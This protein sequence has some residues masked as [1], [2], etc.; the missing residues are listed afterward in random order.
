MLPRQAIVVVVD[1]WQ[2]AFFGAYGNSW[3]ET[4]HLDQ[5]A[6]GGCVFD[7]ALAAGDDLESAYTGYWNARHPLEPT[8]PF[9][10][11][12]A[13]EAARVA[14]AL[15]TDEPQVAGHGAAG[16]FDEL[17]RLPPSTA[18]SSA[19]AVEETHLA[20]VL[21]AAAAVHEELP[22]ASLLWI[23]ARGFSGP[24]DAP[25][26]YRERLADPDD[27][28]PP[29]LVTPPVCRLAADA[30][31]D[32]L[33]GYRRAYGGQVAAADAL[34]GAFAAAISER[35][36]SAETMLLFCSP[37]GYPLGEHGVVGHDPHALY[38]ET[39]HVPVFM[40]LPAGR[41]AWQ[42]S[43][44]LVQPA[45][46]GATLAAWWNLDGLPRRGD[47]RCLVDLICSARPLG[48]D[49]A[50][51]S[52]PQGAA[53][54]RTSAWHLHRRGSTPAA[55]PA[56]WELF[57]KPDDR[58]DQN[59]V[60]DRCTDIVADLVRAAEA[61]TSALSAGQ[62]DELAPLSDRLTNVWR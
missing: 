49:R 23:H 42:R 10:L 29:L 57:A 3:I 54:L 11:S 61:L 19:D 51:A 12:A 62:T 59:E 17:V 16:W 43:S 5:L 27:P 2:P 39:C 21:A 7:L 1:R 35:A 18:D 41:C 32:L 38:A 9:A 22:P 44:T 50:W 33:L 45:D 60:A 13:L 6:T 28:P 55:P 40:S 8:A 48:R 20:R 53:S 37:R 14:T 34:W 15:V 4:P 58:W 52:T 30:D 31:P 56:S 46:I 26:S 24:W 25:R 36:A 47:A